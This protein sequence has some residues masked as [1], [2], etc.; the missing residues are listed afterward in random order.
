MALAI[1]SSRRSDRPASLSSRCARRKG[2]GEDVDLIQA[3]LGV[4][5]VGGGPP[6]TRLQPYVAQLLDVEA[7]PLTARGQTGLAAAG[8]LVDQDVGDAPLGSDGVRAEDALL[9]MLASD[10][11]LLGAD[12]LGEDVVGVHAVVSCAAARSVISS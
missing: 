2:I 7:A 9:V 8:V 1:R 11:L 10:D 5:D 6:R 12:G 4:E 3:G